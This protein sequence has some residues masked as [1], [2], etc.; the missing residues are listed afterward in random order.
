MEVSHFLHPL[1]PNMCISFVWALGVSNRGQIRVWFLGSQSLAKFKYYKS[2]VQFQFGFTRIWL[3][4]SK[5]CENSRIQKK[6]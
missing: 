3:G 4:S 6:F 2:L 1:L 5:S